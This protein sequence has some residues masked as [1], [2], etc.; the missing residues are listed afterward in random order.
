MKLQ[1][2]TPTY[3]NMIIETPVQ[4]LKVELKEWISARLANWINEPMYA[5]MKAKPS[6]M[7]AN[8]D[9][10]EISLKVVMEMKKREA[11]AFVVSIDGNTEKLPE[12]LL[13]MNEQDYDFVQKQIDQLRKKKPT[14]TETPSTSA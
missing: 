12:A 1:T 6:N 14:S 8:I 2:I 9:M 11:E 4:K 10:G 3:L 13:E 5:D 7:G